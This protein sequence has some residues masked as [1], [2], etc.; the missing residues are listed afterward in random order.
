MGLGKMYKNVHCHICP[1]KELCDYAQPEISY[2]RSKWLLSDS[3]DE[4]MTSVEEDGKLHTATANC[5]LKKLVDKE[6]TIP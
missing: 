6:N 4:K 3:Y 1:L 2:K 5:P